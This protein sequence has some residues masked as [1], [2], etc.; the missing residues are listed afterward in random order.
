[1]IYLNFPESIDSHVR[2][3][4]IEKP[5]F[6]KQIT[7]IMEDFYSSSI[8]SEY[9]KLVE[10]FLHENMNFPEDNCLYQL[11]D[12]YF[13]KFNV[14]FELW[15]NTNVKVDYYV[16]HVDDK[17][18]LRFE[19]QFPFLK[20]IKD[21]IQAEVQKLTEEMLYVD[22]WQEATTLNLDPSGKFSVENS[23]LFNF[24]LVLKDYFSP[25]KAQEVENKI[26]NLL[27]LSDK[28]FLLF[29]VEKEDTF[30]RYYIFSDKTI[31]STERLNSDLDNLLAEYLSPNESKK[32]ARIIRN[33]FYFGIVFEDNFVDYIDITRVTLNGNIEAKLE[34]FDIFYANSEKKWYIKATS[35]LLDYLIS[36][37]RQLI[38]REINEYHFKHDFSI[39]LPN[40]D[41]MEFEIEN[42]CDL[43][44]IVNDRDSLFSRALIEWRKGCGV[45]SENKD[46]L[47]K[48]KW[49]A[50]RPLV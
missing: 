45:I 14:S 23:S 3:A 32:L 6:T 47:Q 4:E 25:K 22:S 38:V 28:N 1:M 19:N 12:E 46:K 9:G 11:K 48:L 31:D 37:C 30:K 40:S 49:I 26:L 21:Q 43:A 35:K 34:G 2:Y 29:N 44:I 24:I 7:K 5:S 39:H 10:D 17:I 18:W 42:Y 33:L 36:A 41:L 15:E 8:A 13:W 16:I 20:S 50:V 27:N